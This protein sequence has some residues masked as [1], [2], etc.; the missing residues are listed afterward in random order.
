MELPL[1]LS[2]NEGKRELLKFLITFGG[3]NYRPAA[4]VMMVQEKPLW[5][6]H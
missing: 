3:E 1:G 5:L 6:Q 4:D 2:C